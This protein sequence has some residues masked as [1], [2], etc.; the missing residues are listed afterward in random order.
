MPSSASPPPGMAPSGRLA[1]QRAMT[2][3]VLLNNVDHHDIK[4]M[5]RY[6]AAFGDAV[7][8]TL[9]FPTEFEELQR[10]YPIFFRA[11]DAGSLQPVVLLGLD[12][13]ENLFLEGERW[14]A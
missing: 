6:G 3:P 10:E 13:D 1:R 11:D 14:A 2:R 7:N 4:V 12:R 5:P 9:V 8:Q